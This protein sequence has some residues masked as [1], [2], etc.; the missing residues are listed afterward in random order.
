V[1]REPTRTWIKSGFVRALVQSGATRYPKLPETP[2]IY[3]LLDSHK[4]SNTVK[5]LTKVMLASTDL[6]RPFFAPPGTPTERVKLLRS[7][8]AKTM[9]DPEL[10]AEAKKRNWDIDLTSGEELEKL[11]NEIMIQ[12]PEVIDRVKK[13]LGS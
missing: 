6:G 13:L 9:T 7:S 11:A 8:F 1:S 12:P 5:R 2:T 10:L 3:E 4:A